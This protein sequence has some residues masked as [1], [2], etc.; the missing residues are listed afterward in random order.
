MG[1]ALKSRNEG[2]ERSGVKP[3]N[4]TMWRLIDFYCKLH[5]V[6]YDLGYIATWDGEKFIV[7]SR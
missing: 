1:V 5:K 4:A 2:I 6:V 7:K 3:Q